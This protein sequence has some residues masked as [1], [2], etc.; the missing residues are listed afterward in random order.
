MGVSD[1]FEKLI[2]E[3]GSATILKERI[4]AFKDQIIDLEKENASLK[5]ENFVLKDQIKNLESEKLS[6]EKEKN[7]CKKRLNEI[8]SIT[9]NENHEKILVAVA[10][11]S[12]QYPAV[13]A[14]VTG[15]S[16][17]EVFSKLNYMSSR[18]LLHYQTRYLKEKDSNKLFG[19]EVSIWFVSDLGHA[20]MNAHNLIEKMV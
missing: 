15:L 1:L 14:Q 10:S 3:H 4:V 6:L 20:Y 17:Q 11:F 9:L 16:E 5:S 18:R 7:V 8:H 12:G 13:I 19:K 2:N